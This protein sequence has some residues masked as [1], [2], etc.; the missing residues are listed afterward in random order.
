MAAAIQMITTIGNLTVYHS[1]DLHMVNVKRKG[2]LVDES[3]HII[4]YDSLDQAEAKQE[5]AEA[6]AH[7]HCDQS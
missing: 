2:I 6:W 4:Q 5:E 7:L 3:I 1:P